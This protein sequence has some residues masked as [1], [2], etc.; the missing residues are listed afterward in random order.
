L[1]GVWEKQSG[2]EFLLSVLAGGHE[3]SS[4]S[5]WR[6]TYDFLNVTG[7][8][9]LG[10][11]LQL[12]SLGGFQPKVGDKLTLVT[13]NRNKNHERAKVVWLCASDLPIV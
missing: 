12:I 8:A 3:P 10:G 7:H 5:V 4:K 9:T 11:T 1:R 13:T 6:D 2:D